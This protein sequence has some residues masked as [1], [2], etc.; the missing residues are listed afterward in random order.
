MKNKLI[1]LLVITMSLGLIGCNKEEPEVG[2]SNEP[3][4]NT[5][6]NEV[7]TQHQ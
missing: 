7:V 1:I 4:E 2:I 3:T 6:V 5:A